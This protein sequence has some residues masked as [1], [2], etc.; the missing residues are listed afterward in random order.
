MYVLIIIF[1]LIFLF[2][3]SFNHKNYT[4]RKNEINNEYIKNIVINFFI[5]LSFSFYLNKY[6]K[7][8]FNINNTIKLQNIIFHLLIIDALYYWVHRTSHRIPFIKKILHD[9]HHTKNNLIPTD[10]LNSNYIEYILNILI[11]YYLPLFYIDI[12][13]IEYNISSLTILIH[14]IYLHC[15]AD[16]ILLPSFINSE[17]HKNHHEIGGG[18]Y[19]MVFPIWD[20][21]MNTRIKTKQKK[22]K[23]T[24][25]TKKTKKNKAKK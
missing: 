2:T 17:Y 18:N 7:N 16:F 24:K 14:S 21:F 20:N 1:F 3:I 9:E 23:K 5:A 11:V 25:K 10:F 15:D 12:S 6:C 4:K 22:Q 13:M 19:S 8:L